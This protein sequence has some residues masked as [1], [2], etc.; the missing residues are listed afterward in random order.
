MQ[1]TESSLS[2]SSLGQPSNMPAG[3]NAFSDHACKRT[4]SPLDLRHSKL[5]RIGFWGELDDFKQDISRELEVQMEDPRSDVE[6]LLNRVCQDI[7][8]SEEQSRMHLGEIRTDLE[9]VAADLVTVKSNLTST[10]LDLGSLKVDL[11]TH[12]SEFTGNPNE[13]ISEFLN[14]MER[15]RGESQSNTERQNQT[16]SEKYEAVE[17]R[18]GAL[19][20]GLAKTGGDL[21]AEVKESKS[22]TAEPPPRPEDCGYLT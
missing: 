21:L 11:T 19:G 16:M 5:P 7:K 3:R 15:L 17:V 22:L 10:G 12:Q 2:R 18:L 4:S 6:D 13:A 20:T 1:A 9:A 8:T 14:S